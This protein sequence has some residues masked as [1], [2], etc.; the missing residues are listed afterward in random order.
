MPQTEAVESGFASHL[1][2][3]VVPVYL[4]MTLY[5]ALASVHL[6]MSTLETPLVFTQ[7]PTAALL[8]LGPTT[9]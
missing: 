3:S 4:A 5:W 6:T 9:K 7:S 8:T 2:V 1:E